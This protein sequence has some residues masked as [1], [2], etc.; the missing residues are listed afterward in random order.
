M[1]SDTHGIDVRA[2]IGNS[3]ISLRVSAVCPPFACVLLVTRSKAPA[4]D[5]KKMRSTC[6]VAAAAALSCADA[7]CFSPTRMSS[8]DVLA[9]FRAGNALKVC[10]AHDR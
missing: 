7:F 10:V 1:H 2:C 8:G 6:F 9:P 5:Q 4:A 3:T